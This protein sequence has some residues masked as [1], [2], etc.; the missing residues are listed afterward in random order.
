M[1]DMSDTKAFISHN[2]G[3]TAAVMFSHASEDFVC[4]VRHQSL[5]DTSSTEAMMRDRFRKS[6]IGIIADAVKIFVGERYVGPD[7]RLDVHVY[8]EEFLDK[9]MVPI[10]EIAKVR[11]RS[12]AI[13]DG[14][15]DCAMEEFE[16]GRALAFEVNARSEQYE[17]RFI[18][19]PSP[20]APKALPAPKPPKKDIMAHL[21]L[22]VLE[23][24]MMRL[25]RKLPG[26]S[27]SEGTR[28]S[29]L[30]MI[31]KVSAKVR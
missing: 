5:I 14:M 19:S 9:A 20:Q 24:E 26:L 18:G 7:G 6:V 15:V 11:S 23:I 4:Y 10:P 21:P 1:M 13:I 16:K 8:N 29:Q 28:L 27:D 3:E 30:Y 17:A 22:E 12:K 31:L 2:L 25:E